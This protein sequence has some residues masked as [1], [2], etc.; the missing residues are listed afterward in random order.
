I[1]KVFARKKLVLTFRVTTQVSFIENTMYR[2][3]LVWLSG[4][5]MFVRFEVVINEPTFPLSHTLQATCGTLRLQCE[6][7]LSSSKRGTPFRVTP[8]WPQTQ[9]SPAANLR[10]GTFVF[11][12]LQDGLEPTTP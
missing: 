12:A 1:L 8:S 10:C 11:V 2:T 3:L 7:V 5:Q 6:S 4:F 9:K